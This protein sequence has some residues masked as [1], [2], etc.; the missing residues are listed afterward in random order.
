M[1][2]ETFQKGYCQ[3][4]FHL[5]ANLPPSTDNIE[6]HQLPSAPLILKE[7]R[8]SIFHAK[9]LKGPR[10]D[11]LPAL[12]W[13]EL[14]PVL[15]K[16]LVQL[17]QASFDQGK[18]PYQWKIAKIIPLRKPKKGDYT[19]PEAFRP[20]SLLATLSKACES[21]NANRLSYLNELHQILPGNHFDTL[22]GRSTI[23]A[24]T[25]LQEKIYQ[26]WRD[27]KSSVISNF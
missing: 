5:F 11:G 19:D 25:V 3:P 26:A 9:P 6:Y 1:I 16:V 17:F 13:Q 14:W 18:L 15:G 8:E 4:F 2:M 20:I 21:L 22:K 23:D 24:L 10:Q 27:Q 7:V 12:V